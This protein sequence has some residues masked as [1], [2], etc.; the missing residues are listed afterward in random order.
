MITMPRSVFHF[1]FYDL[2]IKVFS[3]RDCSE[4]KHLGFF[5]RIN[6]EAS[7][8]ILSA[9]LRQHALYRDRSLYRGADILA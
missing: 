8:G 2:K 5:Q 6:K 4:A 1:A 3:S 9:S 7:P